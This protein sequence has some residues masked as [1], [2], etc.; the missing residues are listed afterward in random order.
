MRR[1]VTVLL[2]LGSVLLVGA[3]VWPTQ[4]MEVQLP[5]GGLVPAIDIW[6]WGRVR[7]TGELA[8]VSSGRGSTAVLVTLSACA[9]AAAAA[10]VLWLGAG[11]RRRVA[12]S[13]PV[14]VVLAAVALGALVVT[15]ATTDTDF[16]WWAVAGQPVFSG[17]VA[18]ALPPAVV[19]LWGLAL[20]VMLGLLLRRR[21]GPDVAPTPPGPTAV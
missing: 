16:G 4:R 1:L 17:T 18:A 13:V 11:R 3:L 15:L 19:G 5:G 12:R 2:A 9:L 8:E 14:A 7:V 20:V 21:R 6:L 10:G